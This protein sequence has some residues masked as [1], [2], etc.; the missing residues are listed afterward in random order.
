VS[1][2]EEYSTIADVPTT[3]RS[4]LERWATR[5]GMISLAL[6]V[7]AASVGLLGPRKG[8]TSA[9]AGGS[10]L[11]V[12]Y[13]AITRAGEPAPL[14]IRVESATGFGDKIE[15]AVCDD[16]FDDLDFQN[17]YPNPSGETGDASE[18]S[19]EFDPPDGD[20][21]EV[22]LDARSGP[23]EFGEIQDCTV[24]VVDKGAELV[25]VSFNTWRM[26]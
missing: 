6:V 10:R 12:E 14:N 8:N 24:K 19:Y 25:S 21:L 1:G 3:P 18:L 11:A 22:T 5:A 4:R 26:P 13:P 16:F 15:L 2:S 7:L 20:V 9:S 17:W 23:G